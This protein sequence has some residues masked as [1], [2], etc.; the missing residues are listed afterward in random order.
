MPDEDLRKRF[1]DAMLS[2][3]D[4]QLR[5]IEKFGTLK[6]FKGGQSL[7]EAGARDP[8]FYVI[9]SGHVDGVE[10]STGQPQII[11]TGGPREL[12][13]DVTFLF[14]RVSNVALVAK[15]DVEAF[16]IIPENLRRIIDQEPKLGNIILSA[17][18][19]RIQ[20]MRDLNLTPLRMIG[21][22]FSN[23]AFRIRDFL[24]KNRVLYT[25]V[26]LENDPHVAQMLE[27]LHI[28]EAETPVV[29]FGNDWILR[30]PTNRELA[31]RLG[32]LTSLKEQ[33][34]D[35]AIVGAGP[36]GLTAAVYGASEGLRTV[37][38]E[39]TAPGGQAG[40]SSRIEN[41]PGFPMGISG[42]D[43]AARVYLQA[44]KFGAQVTTP[45]D[46]RSL[47][48]DN[49][50]PVLRLDDGESVAAKCLLIATGASYRRLDVEGVARFEG[51]GI[52]YAATPMEA[53]VCAGSEVVVVGG[54]NSAGQA[55]VFLAERARR[56]FL[57]IR[58]DDINKGMSRYLSRRIEQTDDIEIL[59]NTE[60]A[61]VSGGSH[62]EA[63]EIKNNR[64][65]E[66]RRLNAPAIFTFIGA[67]PHTDWLPKE[68]DTD[69]RGFVK[70]GPAIGDSP[71]W[72]A[73]RPPFF[74]ETSHP[75][76]FAAGDV[77]STSMKRVASAV[78]EGAMAVAFVHQ[79]LAAGPGLRISG[80][81][82]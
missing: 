19:A 49:G 5:I 64:T 72:F 28:I 22:R 18:I 7:V 82:R 1:P 59:T 70:T 40:T 37:V 26:D 21:S 50:Y 20:A 35:L 6:S 24:A 55:A 10:F 43:L 61:S 39:R 65:G 2:F 78:G 69:E 81:E 60:I 9:Y 27:T 48:F 52:Y 63:V 25:W 32:L 47:E 13:G 16:E 41:Y 80:T 23:D 45:C 46:V 54:A 8:N 36:A 76:V 77:R 3:D 12:L 56:V 15:G 44:Q 75:G 51:L 31:E 11:W 58:G 30:N 57:L 17:L 79:Y 68:I 33:L 42:G 74:L 4:E 67:M 14:G 71:A 34:Y 66:T 29:A 62:L 53:Q 38:L 73:H